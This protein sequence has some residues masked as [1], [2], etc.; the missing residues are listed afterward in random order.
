MAFMRSVVVCAQMVLQ[1]HQ[2]TENKPAYWIYVAHKNY[3]TI[4]FSATI[5]ELENQQYH[6]FQGLALDGLKLCHLKQLFYTA[7]K[8]QS[9]TTC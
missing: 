7:W 3:S 4:I 2:H 1:S 9:A 6:W 8:D 5:S